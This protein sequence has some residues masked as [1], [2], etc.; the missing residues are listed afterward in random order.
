MFPL[1]FDNRL[2]L[3]KPVAALLTNKDTVDDVTSKKYAVN[4]L[5][6]QVA[7]LYKVLGSFLSESTSSAAG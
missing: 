4:F 3:V 7:E 5:F 6:T 1:A 2:A